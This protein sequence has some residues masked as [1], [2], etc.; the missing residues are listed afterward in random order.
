MSA[1][2]S[3]C[4]LRFQRKPKACKDCPLMAGLNKKQRKKLLRKLRK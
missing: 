1:H 2:K 4:C 3:K